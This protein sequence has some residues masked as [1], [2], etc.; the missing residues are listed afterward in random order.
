MPT[1]TKDE[2]ERQ[3]DDLQKQLT[4][5]RAK[6]SQFGSVIGQLRYRIVEVLD[7]DVETRNKLVTEVDSIFR[8]A[9]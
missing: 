6:T 9:L 1:K 5:E 7:L 4:A 8:R 3:V 2:L